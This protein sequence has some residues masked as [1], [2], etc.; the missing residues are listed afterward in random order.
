M[1]TVTTLFSL[2]IFSL[3]LYTFL[4]VVGRIQLS[5]FA[6]LL[7]WMK[8]EPGWRLVGLKNVVVK[9]NIWGPFSNKL[10]YISERMLNPAVEGR[11]IK[12]IFSSILFEAGRWRIT[13]RFCFHRRKP[14]LQYLFTSVCPS[15]SILSQLFHLM[16]HLLLQFLSLC[17]VA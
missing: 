10:Y 3:T 17:T 12:T 11:K 9:Y 15:S 6:W 13:M 1:C 14:F 4:Y 16:Y 5:Y 2:V 8:A 7:H